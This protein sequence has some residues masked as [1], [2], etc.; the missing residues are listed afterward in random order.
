MDMSADGGKNICAF[1]GTWTLTSG[2]IIL[3]CG[4]YPSTS[5]LTS[6][7]TL[8]QQGT[9]SDLVQPASTG[10]GCALL[11][12]VSGNTATALPNQT[13]SSSSG[14]DTI[15]LTL[16][17]YTFVLGSDHT[18]ATEIGLGSAVISGPTSESCTYS[19]RATYTKN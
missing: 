18:T 8:W 1:V 13:C 5:Q 16:S 10:G 12:N 2:T 14:P 19:E 9:T 7:E 4:G 17:T 11:A 3:T 6:S 15:N